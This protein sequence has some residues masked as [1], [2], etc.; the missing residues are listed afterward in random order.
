MCACGGARPGLGVR[1]QAVSALEGA[2]RALSLYIISADYTVGHSDGAVVCGGLRRRLVA[3]ASEALCIYGGHVEL[4][5]GRT[6]GRGY[7][8]GGRRAGWRGCG[9]GLRGGGRAGRRRSPGLS[10]A[11]KPCGHPFAGRPRRQTARRPGLR[12]VSWVY[13]YNRTHARTHANRAFIAPP[14]DRPRAH[15]AY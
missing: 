8:R 3:C 2:R 9:R 10:H 5:S 1:A 7:Q 6:G 14:A 12:Q 4:G 13:R 15:D 11:Q